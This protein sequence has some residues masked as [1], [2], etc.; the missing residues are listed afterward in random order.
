MKKS[1]EGR[2]LSRGGQKV[3]ISKSEDAFTV[4]LPRSSDAARLATD[5]AVGAVRMLTKKVARVTVAAEKAPVQARDRLMERLR[6]TGKLV[7]HHEYTDKAN[8]DVSYQITDEI[9]VRFKEGVGTERIREILD[10]V[11]VVIKKEYA[12]LGGSYLVQ[13][14]DAAGANPVKVA[15]RLE[16]YAE[17]EYAE[18]SLVNRFFQFAFPADEL[19]PSQW[20]LYSK[21]Q[22]AP[23]IDRNADA[24]VYEAW[25]ITKGSREIIVA[26]LDDGFELSHPDFQGAGKVVHPTDFTGNDDQPLP[27]AEDYHGTPC[28]GVA[29]AEEN[30][31]G[32]VGAAPRCAFMPVRFPLNAADTWLIEIFRFISARA[33]IVSCSWGMSPGNY[34]LASAVAQTFNGLARSGGKDGKGLV[35]VFAAGNYDAPLDA[36]VNYPIRWLGRDAQG[37]RRIFTA[38][39]RIVNGFPVH[40]DVIAVSA[41]TSLNKKALY[42]NW[43]TQ[44]SVAS[45]SNNFDPTTYNQLPGRGITTTDNEYYGDDFTPGKRY[46]NSFGGTSSATPL[47]AG[48]CALVKS[49]NPALTAAQVKEILEQSADKIEDPAT[50]PLY[51]LA[52]GT[53]S[54]GL[55]EWFGYGKVNAAAAVHEAARRLQPQRVVEK[56]NATTL[57]IPDFSAAGIASPISVSEGGAVAGIEVRVDIAHTWIGDLEVTL[58]SPGSTRMLLHNRGG[59]SADNIQK[60][61]TLIDTPALGAALGQPA[62][63][64]WLL[65]V[66]DRASRDIGTLNRWSLKLLLGQASTV[67]VESTASLTIPDNDPNG[68]A[69]PLAVA[70]DGTLKD[71]KVAV[72][73]THTWIGDL[74]VSLVAP[75]GQEV[76]LHGRS[77]GS[78]D[79]LR[80]SFTP[81]STPVLAALVQAGTAVSGIWT[82][83]AA[84]FARQDEG[85]LNGWSLELSL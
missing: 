25:Q 45:P 15:N 41:I 53:Y 24:S 36:T 26:V 22:A 38:T 57:A 85:K 11:G 77:G 32:C 28:A 69:S 6:E 7:V 17:V 35:I 62:S 39:G 82:L 68:V 29:I 61:Y 51:N 46:T 43:G 19:F 70:Q 56:E 81:Q 34:P 1:D 13:V 63:G 83:K 8:P 20:H 12:H 42:S 5:E 50:D 54:N 37:N 66:A 4:Q 47:V 48:I 33:H 44:L 49:A 3:E 65:Q 76:I 84:D 58:V 75:S 55:S 78:A 23:D 80:Q 14:T 67:R 16:A 59:G 27:E 18:P 21:A 71:I 52:K 60:T 64:S 74:Q 79:N 30:G 10:L 73:I 9:I 2:F 40:P 31:Q 72:D